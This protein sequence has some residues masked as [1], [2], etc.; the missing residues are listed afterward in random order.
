[1]GYTAEQ[2]QLQSERQKPQT[3]RRKSFSTRIKCQSATGISQYLLEMWDSLMLDSNLYNSLHWENFMRIIVSTMLLLALMCPAEVLAQGTAFA[4]DLR[5]RDN[6]LTFPADDPVDLSFIDKNYSPFALDFNVAGDTLYTID[7]NTAQVGTIDPVTGDFSAGFPLTGDYA[8]GAVTGLS[9][10]PTDGSF[11]MSTAADLFMLDVNSGATTLIGSFGIG[12]VIEIA[13][14]SSGQMFAHELDPDNGNGI[15]EGGLY[16]VDKTTAAVTFIG[17]SGLQAVFAQGMDFDPDT[18]TLYAAIYTGGG[19]GSYGTWD[20]T[21]GAF[22]EIIDLPAFGPVEL[23]MAIS[24][25]TTHAYDFRGTPDSFF[26]FPA[27]DP[28]PVT[29]EEPVITYATF[30]MDFDDTGTLMLFDNGSGSFGSIDP[31]NGCFTPTAALSGD[32]TENPV[33]MSF[34]PATGEWWLINIDGLTAEVILYIADPLTGMTTQQA[35]VIDDT[36]FPVTLGIDLA[37][38][39]DGN[40]FVYDL[41]TDA[42]YQVDPATGAAT[43]IGFSGFDANFAQGMDFDPT[44]NILYQAIYTGGGTGSYG[45][46]DL[47]TGVFTEI[48]DLTGFLDPLGT[49]YELEL[50]ITDAGGILGDVNC[51][52]SVDLLDVGPFVDLLLSG[53]FSPKADFDDDQA[54]TLLDV[55]PFVDL[56]TGG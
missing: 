19:T 42:M 8:G 16:S 22:A 54:V 7:S 13:I 52:G 40:L 23:E 2:L 41:A 35:V 32:L 51:D 6:F 46:W 47:S 24:N 26:N 11:Y 14:D 4:F 36:G 39:N 56:L 17:S 20:T 18:D 12:I 3:S 34:N 1:M 27:D 48:L 49:G 31:S 30:A 9:A 10:D 37:F 28:L 29:S 44:T 15:V 38:D 53:G 33:G 5:T 43:L 45:S 50:A 55:G 21:T 25:G